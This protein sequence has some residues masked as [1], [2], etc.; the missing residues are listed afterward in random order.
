MRPSGRIAI[1][2]AVALLLVLVFGR[3][4]AIFYTDVLWYDALGQADVFWTRLLAVAAVRTVTGAVGAAII[5]LNLWYVL[6][7][8]GPVHLRR[9]YGNIEIAEQV[10]RAY[11]IV[12]AVAASVL[13]GW[14]LASIQFGGNTPIALLAWLR[15]E[16]WGTTD[17]LFGRDLSFYIFS[18]PIYT[19]LLDYLLIVL[20]WSA[21]LVG[22]GYVL[23][24]GVRVNGAHWQI[25]DRPRLHFAV[26]AASLLATFAA[27]YLLGRFLLLLDGGGFGGTIGYT[28]VHARLPARLVLSGLAVVTAV[29]IVIGARRRSALP[30]AVAAGVL[31]VAVIGMG[32]AYPAIMQK[33]QVEPNQ[34]ARESEYIRWNMQFTRS[35]YGLDAIERRRF[36]YERADAEVWAEM[37]PALARLPLWDPEPLQTAFTQIQAQR[38]YYQFPDVDYDRYGPAGD[39]RQVA[40]AVREFMQEGLNENARTWRTIHLNPL[41]TR[42]MG[43]VAS[44]VAEK[45]GGEPVYWLGDVQPVQRHPSAPPDLELTEPSVYF[46]ETM[47]EYAVV[48]R[49]SSFADG[50]EDLG[51]Q[52][53]Q[54]PDVTTGVEL[55]SFM[56]VLA[57]AWRFGD[58]NL[59]FARD[60]GQDSRLVF[61]RTVLERLTA[62]APFLLWDADPHPVILDGRI[63]WLVDGYTVSSNY[64]LARPFALQNTAQFS[65]MRGSVKAMVDAVTGEVRLYALPDQDPILAAYRSIFPDLVQDFATMPEALVQHLR[66]PTLL[67]RV[68]SDM[69]EEF[70]LEPDRPDLFY[71]GQD[72]WQ[73]PEEISPTQRSRFRPAFMM[74]PMPGALDPEFLLL[75][76][77]IANERQNMTSMLIARSDGPQY[78]QLVL[79]DIQRDDQVKG[80]AQV[81]SI[82]EQD[83]VI[84]QQLSL[85]RQRGTG[86]EMGRLRI[87]PTERSILYVEPIYLAAQEQGIPQMQRVIVTDGTAVVMADD[88]RAAVSLLRGG[89]VGPVEPRDSA[90][91]AASGASA[92][93]PGPAVAAD[94]AGRALEL[95]RVADERL[96]AGDFAG[97]GEAWAELRALLEER[98]G[99]G[100]GR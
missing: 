71:A 57:F 96:R 30:P 3:S 91:V 27:R 5:L 1:G 10:P 94:V 20:V 73:L 26:L 93:V 24:G 55:G 75:N 31:L 6:R 49:E 38:G 66:Y 21:L 2:A 69:L 28:D 47:A 98:S 100:P 82:I 67:F 56:R 9:R 4:A 7:Q 25:D 64:P 79:L 51:Q 32:A 88:L 19:R 92:A 81:Q 16:T 80:P 84:S 34:L 70:H 52:V 22:I 72:V 13:T 18:L 11:L 39:R 62:V 46:G 86:V 59:L 50:V 74:A 53:P 95:M 41:Y 48:G 36:E 54:V 97:F 87:V 44:P 83:P 23:V 43:A 12:G 61:R 17:P 14:W 85:W 58:Q 63:V 77:F 60:L 33:L 42:G 35:A 90:A 29:T 15:H 65:Y 40:I 78:G 76:V 45:Q 99:G 8:L 68:Q 89:T 37:E